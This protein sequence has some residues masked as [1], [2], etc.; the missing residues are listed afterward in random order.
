MTQRT[1]I[2][3]TE[4]RNQAGD[5]EAIQRPVP[6]QQLWFTNWRSC[7]YKGRGHLETG[8]VVQEELGPQR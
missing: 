6:A 1:V 7:S 4:W 5:S 8:Q 2:P 3:R